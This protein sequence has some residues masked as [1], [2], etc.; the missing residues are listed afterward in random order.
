MQ[1]IATLDPS[2]L[3][4][5]KKAPGARATDRYFAPTRGA[6]G[7]PVV[8]Q[9]ALG[10]ADAPRAPFGLAP[11][12]DESATRR[13]LS[14]EAD[15]VLEA[16][17]S[18]IDATVIKAAVGNSKDWFGTKLNERQVAER[19]S[20]VVQSSD[21][22]PSLVRTKVGEGTPLHAMPQ[23]EPVDDSALAPNARVLPI[24]KVSDVWFANDKFGVSL[25]VLQAAVWP[26]AASTLLPYVGLTMPD[27]EEA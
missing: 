7:K 23:F 6:D 19:Y 26:P 15:A 22:F 21:A 18:A 13:L 20:P 24:V 11:A 12:Y 4:F 3:V 27:D 10:E 14:L 8:V 17:A 2:T 5:G 16:W 1:T 9:L 25:H